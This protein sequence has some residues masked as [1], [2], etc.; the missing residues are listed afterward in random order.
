MSRASH[1]QALFPPAAFCQNGSR[2][3]ADM[4]LLLTNDDGIDAPGLEALGG[5]VDGMAETL[6]MAPDRALS[7]CS[8]RATTDEGFRV[9]RLEEDR[10]S[11][12]GTPADCVRVA[13]HRFGGEIDWVL[14]GINRGGNLGVDVYH[15][16]TVAAARE[17]TLR[18]LPG[19]AVS[20][21]HTRPLTE[22]NWRQASDWTRPLLEELMKRP[23]P[24]STFWNINLPCPERADG[25]PEVVFC[26]LDLSPLPLG[27]RE[28]D[29]LLH[30]DGK[31]VERQHK[32]GADVD[33]CFSGKIAISEI[34]LA[35]ATG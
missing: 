23:H 3:P 34:S 6:V 19:I 9:V 7:G 30:Y 10:Y 5:A 20:Q 33:V 11:V 2:R 12:E 25:Q 18:G 22:A 35:R 17:A 26:P 8:H 24:A 28:E 14:S 1:A 21:F 27:F 13:I 32:P 16:G 31:Y 4:K 15:S 29:G